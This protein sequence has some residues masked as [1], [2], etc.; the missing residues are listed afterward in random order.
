MSK[1]YAAL[2]M[3][4]GGFWFSQS[5]FSLRDELRKLGARV[6]VFR[7]VDEP[8]AHVCI[9][10]YV[11]DGCKLALWGYSLGTSTVLYEQAHR[12]VD[13]IMC[14]AVSTLE[15]TW[16]IA[17]TTQRSILW[18]GPGP[19]SEGGRSLGFTE[20]NVIKI[21]WVPLVSHLLIQVAPSVTR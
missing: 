5:V 15:S 14:C 3:G 7:Y 21:P 13:L 18:S 2:F 17:K 4:Q 9:D 16:K 6:D 10:N 1:V 11:K 8:T 12:P 19:L 20:V